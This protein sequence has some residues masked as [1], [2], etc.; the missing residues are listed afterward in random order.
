MA[1]TLEDI[2]PLYNQLQDMEER[3]TVLR[4]YL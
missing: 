4:G 3:S 2:N 1:G